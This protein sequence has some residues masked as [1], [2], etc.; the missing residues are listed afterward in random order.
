MI[1]IDKKKVVDRFG[2]RS[3]IENYRATKKAGNMN[4][5]IIESFDDD[6]IIRL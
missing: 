5:I 3:I 4:S 2:Q 6:L 1:F